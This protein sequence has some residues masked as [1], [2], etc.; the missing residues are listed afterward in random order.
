MLPVTETKTS[1]HDFS[2]DID[3]DDDDDDGLQAF[4]STFSRSNKS[5]INNN[6]HNNHKGHSFA[7]AHQDHDESVMS[8][9]LSVG[10]DNSGEESFSMND[11]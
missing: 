11:F 1:L 6:S 5:N 3:D 7:R 2:D 8:D 4:S 10:Q 9:N